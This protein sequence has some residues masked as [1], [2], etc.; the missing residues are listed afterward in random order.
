MTDIQEKNISL[1]IEYI[2]LG[3]FLIS[4]IVM[5]ILIK[6][7]YNFDYM[8]I[9]IIDLNNIVNKNDIYLLLQILIKRIKQYAFFFLIVK[10]TK[11]DV[12]LNTVLLILSMVI[13][14]FCTVNC[15]YLGV[16]G[17]FLFIILTF[18]HFVFYY[19]LLKLTNQFIRLGSIKNVKNV[20]TLVLIFVTGMLC[21]SFFLKIFLQG[22]LNI[23]YS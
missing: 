5:N 10:V 14:L 11:K 8:S 15:Y 6:V 7:G 1:K 20:I 17:L 9:S 2:C 23:L 21:E 12:A 18:P 3:A 22:F 4:V 19:I 16:Q 13:G